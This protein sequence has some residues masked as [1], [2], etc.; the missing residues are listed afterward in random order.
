MIGGEK[1]ESVGQD[2]LGAVG[3][4][5]GGFA[6]DDAGVEQV[7]HVA[8]EGDLAEADDDA[9]AGECLD[10]GGEV[11][12]TVADLLR[13]GFVS[14]RRAT[15]NGGDPGMAE[16]EAVVAGGG[17]GL[18]GESHLMENGI[19]EIAG[20]ITGEDAARAVGAVGS[21]GQAKDE[22]AGAG[23]AK[24]GDRPGPV[25]LILVGATFGFADAP[26]VV[27]EPGA[28]FTGDDGGV[29]LLQKL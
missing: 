10:L 3:E 1:V 4:A 27:A 24:A 5:V 13:G 21:R 20:A 12:G 23:V 16:L 25:G 17:G 11:G 29:N 9:D 8:I 6:G 19:H 14:G 22:D 2:V 26:A 18:V 7:G 15:D 28:A